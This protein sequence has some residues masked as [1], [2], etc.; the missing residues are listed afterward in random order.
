MTLVLVYHLLN[1]FPKRVDNSSANASSVENSTVNPKNTTRKN[2][3]GTF[4]L[5]DSFPI[6]L[7]RLYILTLAREDDMFGFE[8]TSAKLLIF[9]SCLKAADHLFYNCQLDILNQNLPFRRFPLNCISVPEGINIILRGLGHI[10]TRDAK[11]KVKWPWTTFRTALVN[12]NLYGRMAMDTNHT[13]Q[14]G[15]YETNLVWNDEEGHQK[16]DYYIENYCRDKIAKTLTHDDEGYSL[17]DRSAAHEWVKEQLQEMPDLLDLYTGRIPFDDSNAES[18][19]QALGL[20][21]MTI[22]DQ[23]LVNG[24]FSPLL[25]IETIYSHFYERMFSMASVAPLGNGSLGQVF[26]AGKDINHAYTAKILSTYMTDDEIAFGFS[27]VPS[28][29]FELYE[30]ESEDELHSGVESSIS[31]LDKF[32]IPRRADNYVFPISPIPA[33][34]AGD[35]GHERGSVQSPS[36]WSGDDIEFASSLTADELLVLFVLRH[37]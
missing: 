3:T 5:D 10:E 34:D 12:A 16:L 24:L 20:K 26:R 30:D 35:D 36:N 37:F 21:R 2:I 25:A 32:Y 28:I 4:Q 22:S 17:M 31:F 18:S 8:S 19:F 6:R 9:S 14:F 29:S 27:L 11:I 15:D 1:R 13:G 23:A 33:S 7:C